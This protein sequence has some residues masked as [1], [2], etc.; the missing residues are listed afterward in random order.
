LLYRWD[1]LCDRHRTYTRVQKSPEIR[2]IRRALAGETVTFKSEFFDFHNIKVTPEPIQKPH[3]P[4]WLGGFTPAA[5]R[6]AARFGDGFTVPGANRDVYDRYVAELQKENRPT[7][8]IRFA[9]STWCLIVS[10]D[11]EKTF[12]EA[13]DHIIYQANNYGIAKCGWTSAPFRASARSRPAAAKRLSQGRRPR[14]CDQHNSE[15]PQE[16]PDHALLFVDAAAR[17]AAAMGANASRVVRLE[18]DSRVLLIRAMRSSARGEIAE[19][20]LLKICAPS[21]W[22]SAANRL[23]CGR[24]RGRG[25][26]GRGQPR[27][28][29]SPP[30]N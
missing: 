13:A 6:R 25:A 24:H 28:S 4:I 9:S 15:L 19:R 30:R 1:L 18:G 8:D 26:S 12:A 23:A 22:T 7:D 10:D 3:P 14:Y 20:S 11:P 16:R 17:T 2:I 29:G 27:A 21:R 5:L